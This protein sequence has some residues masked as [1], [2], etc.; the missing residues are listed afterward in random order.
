[1]AR[2]SYIFLLFVIA[3]GSIF[4]QQKEK[5]S[6]EVGF[7]G[8]LAF[9]R[10]DLNSFSN[11][12]NPIRPGVG[13]IFRRNFNPRYAYRINV[14]AGEVE[15][16]DSKSESLLQQERNLSF[17]SPILEG[18]LQFEF[19]YLYF[20]VGRDKSNLASTYLFLGAGG[21]WFNPQTSYN[22]NWVNLQPLGTEGQGTALN[23]EA[24]YKRL[25]PS[26]PMGLGLKIAL[27]KRGCLGFEWG[28]RK[29]FTDYIDDVS[30]T[31][32]DPVALASNSGA[33]S[34]ALSNRSVYTDRA[35]PN[36]TGRQRGNSQ[37]KDWYSFLGITL[38][39]KFKQKEDQCPGVM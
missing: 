31:Y 9:Y 2:T 24:K 38:S 17:R 26:F 7:F 21:F 4:A 16:W 6:T 22:G 1:M 15:A 14:F 19:N 36:M 37:N 18:S 13:L 39:Y 8:G 32:V 11:P 3:C 20:M 25:Q 27:G 12:L 28:M 5:P 33:T 23:S 30:G 29:T 10:G 35:S 34:A